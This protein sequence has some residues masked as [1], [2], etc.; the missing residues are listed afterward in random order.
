MIS[1]VRSA[2]KHS[3]LWAGMGALL[4]GLSAHLILVFPANL[5]GLI[6]GFA[7]YFRALGHSKTPREAGLTCGSCS[8]CSWR[9]AAC[10]GSPMCSTC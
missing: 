2:R 5:L 7:C 1:Q 10:T 4:V 6:G 9:P 8:A 3:Y